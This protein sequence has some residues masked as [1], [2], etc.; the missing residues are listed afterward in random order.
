MWWSKHPDTRS[1]VES[2]RQG[3]PV[4]HDPKGFNHVRCDAIPPVLPDIFLPIIVLAHLS[5]LIWR[6][7]H[8]G[9]PAVLHSNLKRI[10]NSL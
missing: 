10:K 8:G 2:A 7:R 6:G 4:D 5:L 1:I 9:M 3:S